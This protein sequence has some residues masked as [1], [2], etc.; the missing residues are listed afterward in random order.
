MHRQRTLVALPGR[1]VDDMLSTP[2]PPAPLAHDQPP[3]DAG[4]GV[5]WR[6]STARALCRWGVEG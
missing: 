1:G 4:G 6:G 3:G 5:T 2:P